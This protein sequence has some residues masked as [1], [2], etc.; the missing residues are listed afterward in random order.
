VLES[1]YIGRRLVSAPHAAVSMPARKLL[2]RWR[3]IVASERG[4]AS[5]TTRHVLLTLSLHMGV[6]G[7]RAFPSERCLAAETGLSERAV[8]I[9]LQQAIDAG[10]IVRAPRRQGRGWARYV[11]QAVIPE[12]LRGAERRSGLHPEPRAREA[13]YD[14]VGV[15]NEVRTNS[16]RISTHNAATPP[17]PHDAQFARRHAD[18]QAFLDRCR[19]ERNE[20]RIPSKNSPGKA[21]EQ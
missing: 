11:Y 3:W 15:P 17:A 10:W 7:D 8:G 2:F 19:K 6:D 1:P 20:A 4:P 5:P 21:D 13:E 14:G 18:C 9:H 12:R 16:T